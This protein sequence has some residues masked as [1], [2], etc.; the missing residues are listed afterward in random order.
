MH[1]TVLSDGDVD[2]LLHTLDRDDIIELHHSLADALHY[3]SSG[4]DDPGNSCSSDCQ[5]SRIQI[6]RK[7]GSTTLFMPGSSNDGLGIKVVTLSDSETSSSASI[8]ESTRS[9]ISSLSLSTPPSNAS[10]SSLAQASGSSSAPESNTSS[11]SW[12]QSLATSSGSLQPSTSP[13]GTLT[14]LDPS[15]RARA[16]VNAAELTA[17][18]TALAS[19][20]LFNKRAHVHDVLVFGAGRQAYWHARLAL[21]LRAGEVHHLDV[22]NR[23]FERAA[24][25]LARL[26]REDVGVRVAPVRTSVLTP[27]HGEYARLLRELV[28]KAAAVF[29]A[30]ASARPLFPAEMLTSAEARRRGR[31]VAA[32]GAYKPHV[33]EL[34]PD[35]I[36]QAVAPPHKGVHLHRHARHGGVVVVD[37]VEACLREA[38]EL[39]MAGVGAREVVELGELVMLKRDA[40]RRRRERAEYEAGWE[41]DGVEIP[42]RERKGRAGHK[43][44]EEDGGLKEWLRTGSVIY[45]SVG[46]ALMV[47]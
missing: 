36:R 44:E 10:S 12:P 29:L 32:V 16:F 19:T 9:S 13:H 43:G 21:L 40:E 27:A 6:T 23:G 35:V 42:R 5:P 8:E 24:A 37:S 7:D 31:Y 17:F 46:L 4:D 15:G 25:M 34:H 3:Y 30:T 2:R 41:R 22:V 47:S 11:S 14:L 1:L 26:F 39:V 45:K 18:R 28:R 33:A 38:G 20:L